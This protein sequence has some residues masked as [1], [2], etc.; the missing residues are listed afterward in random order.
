MVCEEGTPF[1]GAQGSKPWRAAV[2]GLV[3]AVVCVACAAALL[4][5]PQG[6]DG[7]RESELLSASGQGTLKAKA[8]AALDQRTLKAKAKAALDQLEGK[9]VPAPL[10][11]AAAGKAANAPAAAVKAAAVKAA[12]H[13]V[14]QAAP[15][16]VSAI[17]QLEGNA[18]AALDQ[19]EG[20]S[21]A[22]PAAAAKGAK[23][24]ATVKGKTA[25]GKVGASAP[26]KAAETVKEALTP[27][28]SASEVHKI[29]KTMNKAA[30]KKKQV[31][32]AQEST[33]HRMQ[34]RILQAKNKLAMLRLKK[35]QDFAKYEKS[36]EEVDDAKSKALQAHDEYK[37][38]TE[39][40]R[41]YQ[42]RLDLLRQKL[43]NH[44]SGST[45]RTDLNK[46][47][48]HLNDAAVRSIP[49]K[50]R[51]AD[52]Q[53]T[54]EA[55][56]YKNRMEQ[57]DKALAAGARGRNAVHARLEVSRRTVSL[58]EFPQVNVWDNGAAN[59]VDKHGDPRPDVVDGAEKTL[60]KVSMAADRE[61]LAAEQ[62]KGAK[63]EKQP[64]H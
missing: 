55:A 10:A 45:A 50:I 33:T 43:A 27:T 58:K 23:G 26:A 57:H 2:M 13:A 36:H 31:K 24:A 12:A 39:R 7:D 21:V 37:E 49:K 32:I 15:P 11:A 29:M 9:S 8:K 59:V 3:V 16:E 53:S 1:R 61:I 34:D 46:Y 47:Y 51:E 48:A 28:V 4:A 18:A 30:A 62:A 5:D 19:L 64:Q 60:N 22:A 35:S 44:L 17:D 20:K 52:M 56:L 38:D 41:A 42:K 63:E 6:P 25:K 14:K 54:R 40:E